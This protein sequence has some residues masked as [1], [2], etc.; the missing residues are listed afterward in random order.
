MLV[1]CAYIPSSPDNLG[2]RRASDILPCR[3]LI[4]TACFQKY[5]KQQTKNPRTTHRSSGFFIRKTEL[6]FVQYQ[7]SVFGKLTCL[8]QPED[9]ELFVTPLS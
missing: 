7:F 3:A 8:R 9:E 2:E 5:D 6:I 1:Q 4:S